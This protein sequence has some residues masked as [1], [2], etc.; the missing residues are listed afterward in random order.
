MKRRTA[1]SRVVSLVQSLSDDLIG[2]EDACKER[3]DGVF[4]DGISGLYDRV[5][6]HWQKGHAMGGPD[7]VADV[8]ELAREAVAGAADAF[9]DLC[10]VAVDKGLE[11]VRA[12][13]GVCEATLALRYAGVADRAVDAVHAS[14]ETLIQLGVTMFGTQSAR[15]LSWFRHEVSREMAG[16]ETFDELIERLVAPEPVQWPGHSGRGLWWQIT[17][18][19]HQITRETEFSVVNAARAEAMRVMNEIGEE[20]DAARL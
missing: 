16:S 6:G 10:V 1:S 15:C 11:S 17:L 8:E 13:L 5:H 2:D 14:A 4:A 18:W 7:V 19:L 20:I 3:M 12:E 9:R